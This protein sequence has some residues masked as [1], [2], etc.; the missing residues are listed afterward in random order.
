MNRNVLNVNIMM[1]YH[2]VEVDFTNYIL[3]LAAL[4]TAFR[5]EVC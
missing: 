1:S 3:R 2:Y 5:R 4:F